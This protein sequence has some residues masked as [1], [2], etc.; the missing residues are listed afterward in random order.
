MG[1]TGRGQLGYTFKIST[2]EAL[3]QIAKIKAE[4]KATREA[5]LIKAGYDVKPL[6]EYQAGI[7]KIKQ[8]VLALAKQKQDQA[9]ADKS[10]S[11]ALQAALRAEAETRR[12]TAAAEKKDKQ[13]AIAL[14]RQLANEA[15]TKR[16]TPDLSFAQTQIDAN[17]K[18]LNSTI[19]MESAINAETVA[20]ARLN[21][22]TVKQAVANGGITPAINA[23]ASASQTQAVATNKVTLSKQQLHK[24]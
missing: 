2:E 8:E 18:F 24:P 14:S 15:N 7:L 6:T 20:R 1:N 22:E 4:L 10:A 17:T 3:K 21:A 19:R 23:N 5:G 12:A 16:K 11:L 13:D 9:A